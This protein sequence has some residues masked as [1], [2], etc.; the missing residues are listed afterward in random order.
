MPNTLK[1]YKLP[2]TPKKYSAAFTRSQA[3]SLVEVL[4]VISIISLLLS[5]LLPVTNR[6]RETARQTICQS[7]LRQWALA[8]EGYAMQNNNF[9]PHIDG[10]DY[11]DGNAD[12]FGWVDVLPPILGHK[13]WRDYKIWEKPTKGFFQCPAAKPRGSGYG[14]NP[15]RNGYFSY[16][17]NSCLEL[18]NSCWPPYGQPGG[19]NM[20]SFLNVNLIKQPVR[21]ILLF[22]QLLDP[23]KGF[24][25][26]AVNL[27]AG[28]HCGAYPRDFSAR[29]F[30]KRG[31]LGGLILFCDYH[32]EWKETVWKANWPIDDPKFQAPPRD[33]PDWYPYQ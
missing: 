14:Y 23:S 2:K 32:I 4:V 17:M 5:I 26:F 28:E 21:V 3:F 30:K 31:S 8:F 19:N 20:P 24:G 10:L 33:D 13:R 25:G 29:H 7:Q 12:N 18:D 27:S 22:D 9:Y 1:N 16:A 11:N 15:D 6:V